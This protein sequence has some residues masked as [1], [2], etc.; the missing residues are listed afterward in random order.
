MTRTTI[1]AQDALMLEIRSMAQRLGVSV[2]EVIRRALEDFVRTHA[3]GASPSFIGAGKSGGGFRVSE[4]DEDLL[5]QDK[6]P[7]RR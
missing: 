4:R 3:E 7:K 2:S 6:P 5:F 1:L